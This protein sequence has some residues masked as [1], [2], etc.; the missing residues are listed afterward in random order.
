[1][2]ELIYFFGRL[3]VLLLHLPI[4]ILL[5]AVVLEI[6]SRQERF[7]YL[8]S[9]LG[10]VWAAGALSAI[11]T[12]ALGYMHASEGG[13][14]GD[15]LS[16]H[17]LAGTSLAVL[18]CVIWLT[19]AKAFEF[20]G[21][22]WSAGSVG[23]VLLLFLTG[24]FGGNLTHGDTYLAEYAP[25]PLRGLLG[26]EAAA[27][28]RPKPTSLESADIYLDVVAPSLQQRCATCHNENKRKGEF[29]VATH[30]DLM[31]GGK[32]GPAIVAGKPEVSDLIRRISVDPA[33]E[34]FMPKD[35]KTPLTAE[36][37]A[38][39]A[40]WVSVGAPPSGEIAT[41]KPTPQAQAALASVLGFGGAGIHQTTSEGG[42]PQMANSAAP[43]P[44]PDLAPA[45]VEAV[46]ALESNGFVVRPIAKDHPLVQVD[47]TAHRDITDADMAALA[48]IGPQIYALNLRDAGLVDQQLETV[49]TFE[50]LAHL[51]LELNPITD[52]GVAQLQ[53]LEKLEYLNLY[54]TKL[55][56]KGIAQLAKLEKLHDLF[57]WQTSIT[58][59][60][61][62]ELK[63]TRANLNV[64]GGFDPRTFPVGPKVIPVIN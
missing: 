3:H 11:G 57:V 30:A 37:G 45:D 39:I 62:A 21:K 50:N 52:A 55:S 35:G 38:A 17:R 23:V 16:A 9:A 54:G 31:K 47:Y 29:S 18:A 32:E 1:M 4:G 58:T 2:T 59:A 13:F 15:A 6:V 64:N 25:R 46:N 19:R 7:R 42:P 28:A 41:L 33:H 8:Q 10:F 48:R 40:W 22:A 14:E 60:G 43:A 20:Y 27:A 12:A 53:G 5:L 44:P 56:D 61:I 36:Q 51:R 49:G 24:H 26:H 34:D 63:R